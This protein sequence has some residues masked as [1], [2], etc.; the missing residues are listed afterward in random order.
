M[1]RA[2]RMGDDLSHTTTAAPRRAVG[3]TLGERAV[4]CLYVVYE[5]ARPLAAPLRLV[6]E[7][8]DAVILGRGATRGESTSVDSGAR[9]LELRIPDARMSSRHARL[10][11]VLGRW[12]LEDLGSKNGTFMG[13]QPVTR[14]ELSGRTLLQLGQTWLCFDPA[15]RVPQGL[16]LPASATPETA[17]PLASLVPRQA[18]VLAAARAVA[19]A[20]VPILLLGP[21]GSGKEVTARALHA[22]SQRPG[23]LVAVNCG[24]LPDT[25]VESELFGHKKGAFSGAT[26]DR[27]GLVRAADTGTLFLDEIGDL[28]LEA[29]A[30]LL[31]ALQ[32]REVMPVGAS[33]TTKVDFRSV[34]ATHRDVEQMIEA[35]TFRRDLYARI[36]GLVVPLL[37]LAERLEDLG[38]LVA[39]HLG[40]HPV[41]PE[42]M[43]A[44]LSHDWPGNVRELEQTL[45]TARILAGA[46]VLELAHLPPVFTAVLSAEDHSEP[47]DPAARTHRDEL[48]RQLSAHRGNVS[49]VA[50]AMGKARMQIQRWMK[51]YA[52]SSEQFRGGSRAG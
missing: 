31:R 38:L 3:A 44:L 32:E 33:R 15:T 16:V 17:D 19:T 40:E 18:H 13:D 36:A 49:A 52:L 4:P 34:A 14:A 29:Q 30:A 5:H 43:L 46:G 35:G 42:V 50:R 39:R 7:Q 28:P 11:R 9:V 27:V 25:L 1:L 26:E 6:L 47:D 22:L 21:T 48:V 51:R 8:H 41:A 12:V 37:P 2:A 24:A 20:E 10:S 23:A 45:R